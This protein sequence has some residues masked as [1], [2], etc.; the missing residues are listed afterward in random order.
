MNGIDALNAYCKEARLPVAAIVINRRWREMLYRTIK[1]LKDYPVLPIVV[2]T[3]KDLVK[4]LEGNIPTFSVASEDFQKVANLSVAI[5]VDTTFDFPVK[6]KVIDIPHAFPLWDKDNE[7]R[8]DALRTFDFTLLYSDVLFLGQSSVS[9]LSPEE[10]KA[11]LSNR[12]PDCL[13]RRKG[14]FSIVPGGYLK[15]DLLA[16]KFQK[17]PQKRSTILVLPTISIFQKNTYKQRCIDMI[18]A[19]LEVA[20]TM[21]DFTVTF[22]PFPSDQENDDT[23]EIKSLFA[24]NDKFIFD[25]LSSTLPSFSAAR[26]IIT[27]S[28]LGR[29]TFTMASGL[30]HI[31]YNPNGKEME[32]FDGGVITHKK[33]HISKALNHFLDSQTEWDAKVARYRERYLLNYGNAYSTLADTVTSLAYGQSGKDWI[34]FDRDYI[35]G[36]WSNPNSWYD[37]AQEKKEN[38]TVLMSI[39]RLRFPADPRFFSKEYP[40]TEGVRVNY[41]S[42]DTKPLSTEELLQFHKNPESLPPYMVWGCSQ[43]YRDYYQALVHQ[44]KENC[45]GFLDKNKALWGEKFDGFDI[46]PP[47][48]LTRIRPEVV[49]IATWAKP[50]VKRAILNLLQQA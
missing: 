10:Y 5:V 28:S 34:T 50:Q 9:T 31:M 14:P 19:S 35:S 44:A 46:H 13:D 18:K 15:I 42:N 11:A 40:M 30:P 39:A 6:T 32:E 38:F 22:R 25:S 7:Q 36:D 33:E 1:S 16:E 37:L 4:E 21:N 3:D 49:F 45:L 17:S 20:E 2:T 47:Q 12:Y 41:E 48:E 43:N 29:V 27:D 8:Q 26:T 24:A 23:N